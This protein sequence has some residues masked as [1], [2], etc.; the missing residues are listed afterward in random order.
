[1]SDLERCTPTKKTINIDAEHHAMLEE[2]SHQDNRPLGA[3][4]EVL[5]EQETAR[6]KG[7]VVPRLQANQQGTSGASSELNQPYSPAE[8]RNTD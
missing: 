8:Q 3:Q 2:L 4:A 1:M 7:A 6:R 5:I